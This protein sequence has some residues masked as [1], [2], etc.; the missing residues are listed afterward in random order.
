MKEFNI[1]GAVMNLAA[2][3]AEAVRTTSQLIAAAVSAV[4]EGSEIAEKNAE[5]M[6]SVVERYSGAQSR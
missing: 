3:S 4:S 5:P 6:E 1:N 2:K